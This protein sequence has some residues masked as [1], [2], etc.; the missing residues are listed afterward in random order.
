MATILIVSMAILAGLIAFSQFF[1]FETNKEDR[2]LVLRYKVLSASL[3]VTAALY[4]LTYLLYGTVICYILYGID[5]IVKVIIMIEILELTREVVGIEERYISVFLSV[6]TYGASVLYFVDTILQGGVLERGVFG[7]YL[8]PE[9]PWHRVLYFFYYMIYMIML[10]TFIVI[11]G[12]TIIKECEKH[13]FVF[14][15]IVYIIS[16]FGFMSEVFI[17]NYKVPYFPL[18]L[19]FNTLSVVLI[20]Y[21]FRYHESISI[22]EYVFKDELDPSRTDIVFVL[23]DQMSVIYQN[24]RAE[25][26]GHL[27][28]DEYMGRKLMDVFEF[29]DAALGQIRSNLDS[30]PFGISAIYRP[31]GRMVNMIIQHKIDR[32][33]EALATT[34]F[35]YNMED[36]YL[37]DIEIHEGNNEKETEDS[38][39][40]AAVTKGA[41]VLIVD[42]D[43]LFISVLERM[44]EEYDITVTKATNGFEAIELVK[45]NVYDIIFIT[46]EMKMLDGIRTLENIR[47]LKGEYFEQVPVVYITSSDINEVFGAFIEAGFSDYLT[48]PVDKKALSLALSRWLW[49]RFDDESTEV[50][51]SYDIMDASFLEMNN[52]ISTAILMRE[53]DK[54]DKLLYCIGGIRKLAIKLKMYGIAEHA[55]SLYEAI[56]IDDNERIDSL[57]DRVINGVREAISMQ[58]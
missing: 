30:V 9:A 33:K 52:L 34:V 16:A 40:V 1:T 4:V 28:N 44:L 5:R 51:T 23:N 20:K 8:Y 14:L 45:K 3:C 57:F 53:I 54:N 15:C 43:E 49:K 6:I 32:Y 27:Y 56:E 24:K 41:R 2:M 39:N 10:I 11:K 21:L 48:K 38:A 13:E 37:S 50:A 26:V 42:E 18:A 22:E 29:S 35:V 36:N 17:I 7:V 47:K 19:F 58:R 12:T 55:Y 25:I 46:Y 31:N